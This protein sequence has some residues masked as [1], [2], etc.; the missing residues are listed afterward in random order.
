M[1]VNAFFNPTINDPIVSS[2]ELMHM[3]DVY[4]KLV[5]RYPRQRDLGFFK[6]MGR[7][8]PV[9][10]TT[11][12]IHEE[13]RLIDYVT[14]AGHT[15]PSG[16]LVRITLDASNHTSAGTK[17]YPRLYD[18]VEF[19][20]MAQGLIVAKN[21]SVANAHTIDIQPV[22]ASHNVIAAAVTGDALGM[23]SQAHDEGGDGRR[24][25]LV[26]TTTVFNNQVQLFRDKM[27]VTSS[28]QGNETWI[29][30]FTFP[31]GHPRAGETGAFL[32][33]KGEADMIDR[34]ELQREIGLMTND[35]SD[36][37]LTIQVDGVDTP[38]RTT[39][40]FIPH[41]KQYG[42]LMD[43]V[44]QPGMGTF[45][46]IVKIQ[47][48][49][50]SDKESMIMMGLNFAL[51][52][53][54]FGVDLL[55]DGARIYSSGSG[56]MDAVSLGFK[57][58]QFPTGHVFHLKGLEALSHADTTGL[59]GMVYPDLAIVCP[60]GT[61]KDAKTSM[62]MDA[63]AIKYKVAEGKGARGTYKIWET[64][65]NSDAGTNSSLTRT[66]EVACEQGAQVYGGKRFIY[67]SKKAS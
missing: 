6:E 58:I 12:Q 43:Y 48:K 44:N 21:T 20:N 26:P 55:K 5:G 53:K 36:S 29:K 1:A 33:I 56:E 67:C 14:I 23:F 7:M 2:M 25:I 38:V 19:L 52:F 9:R 65:G 51:G 46:T 41:V 32:Y 8:A 66:L 49:N 42:E 62:E 64:G 11:Y 40:G 15:N 24:E 54:N 17:S 3:P 39:R 28:E 18:R 16:S 57:S 47:N 4:R 22:S 59:P 45:D 10:Q 34:Y 30:D 27:K 31:A 35:I 37:G 63:F 50:Y 61:V 60:T 13:N